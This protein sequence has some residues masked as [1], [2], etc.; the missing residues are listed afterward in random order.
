MRPFKISLCDERSYQ[1]IIPIPVNFSKK[2]AK[3]LPIIELQ[4]VNNTIHVNLCVVTRGRGEDGALLKVRRSSI[5]NNFSKKFL[6][7]LKSSSIFKS[8]R[9]KGSSSES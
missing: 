2:R 6:K 3:T 4:E 8:N 9:A 7:W 5:K 1:L